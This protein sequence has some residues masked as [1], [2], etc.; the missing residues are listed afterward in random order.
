MGL[1]GHFESHW[2][3]Q[4]FPIILDTNNG[5]NKLEGSNSIHKWGENGHVMVQIGPCSP[6]LAYSVP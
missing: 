1:N 4:W 6:F 5:Q 2:S 3:K